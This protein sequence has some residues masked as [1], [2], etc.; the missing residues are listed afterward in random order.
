M[1]YNMREIAGFRTI[2]RENI[3]VIEVKAGAYYACSTG[4]TLVDHSVFVYQKEPVWVL[5]RSIAVCFF[6]FEDSVGRRV[7]VDMLAFGMCPWGF[8]GGTPLSTEGWIV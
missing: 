6:K 1:T 4:G 5:A 8:V 2:I 7:Y 3:V